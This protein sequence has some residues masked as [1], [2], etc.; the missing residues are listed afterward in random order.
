MV[1]D[2]AMIIQYRGEEERPRCI[3]S[4]PRDLQRG[5]APLGEYFLRLCSIWAQRM[6]GRPWMENPILAVRAL[7]SDEPTL[8]VTTWNG[9]RWIVVRDGLRRPHRRPKDFPVEV[10]SS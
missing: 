4:L 10:R 9:I 7:P 1:S 8:E 3:P 2:E 6:G 5:D